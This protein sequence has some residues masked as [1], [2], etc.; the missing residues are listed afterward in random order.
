MLDGT[1]RSHRI[2]MSGWN[3]SESCLRPWLRLPVTYHWTCLT[4]GLRYRHCARAVSL[5]LHPVV[6]EWRSGDASLNDLRSNRRSDPMIMK[7]SICSPSPICSSRP[8]TSVRLIRD[9]STFWDVTIRD[10]ISS[11][12]GSSW[13]M[14]QNI[15]S[16]CES[17]S[18]NALTPVLTS[19]SRR[20]CSAT[21]QRRSRTILGV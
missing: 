17:T 4:K 1:N 21:I 2:C 11:R 5:R 14:T 7:G 13:Q 10:R 9:R 12:K 16:L 20:F 8:P 19:T 3:M 15:Y 18:T 6:Q